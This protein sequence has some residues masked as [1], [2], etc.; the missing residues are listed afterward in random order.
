MIKNK[1]LDIRLE[2]KYKTQKQFADFLRINVK[3]YSQ[4]ENNKK[5][6]SLENAFKIANKLNLKIEQIWQ[7]SDV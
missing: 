7:Y 1:L 4:I 3:T 6:V 2:L 5:Q